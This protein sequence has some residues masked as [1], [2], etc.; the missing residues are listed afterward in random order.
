MNT[1]SFPFPRCW[2][3]PELTQINRLPARSFHFPFPNAEKAATRDPAKSKWVRSLD[4]EWNFDYF[5]R[6]EAVPGEWIGQVPG[7]TSRIQVPGNW[8]R[9]GW[10]KPH[11][12]NV[13]M[14]FENT[15]PQV[16]NDNPTGLYRK[17]ISIPKNWKGRRTLLQLG[18]V[19][20]V[21]GVY[22]DGNFVGWSTDSRLPAEFDL[23]PWL[24]PGKEHLLSVLVIR[25]SAFS[26]VED[27]DHWWMAGI[28][29]SV[30]LI[31]TDQVWFEDIFAKTAYKPKK[32]VGHLDLNIQ[33][34]LSG[35][36]GRKCVVHVQLE[37][38]HGKTLWKKPLKQSV[39]GT[40]YRTD[41]FVAEFYETVE[42]CL[43]WSAEQPHL[44]K[45][46]LELRDEERGKL[47]EATCIRI[48]FKSVKIKKGQ[49][50]FNGQPILIKGVNRHDHDPDHGK[51]MDRKW[52]IEDALLLKSHNFN[53]VRTAHYPNDPTWLEICDEVG[54]YVIDEANQE[55]HAN[56]ET[57]GHDPRWQNTCVERATRMVMR[58]RNH[59]S[60]YAWSLGNET[61]YGRNHDLEADA[62][63]VLDDSRLL[64]NEPADRS[65]WKQ[66]G[67]EFTPGGERSSDFRCPMYPEV[68]TFI[69]YGKNPTDTR[70]FI[71]CEYSHAMGNSNGCLKD[72]WDAI[73]KYPSLQGGYIWDWVEQGL[74]ESA[75]NGKE[76]WAY[77]GDFGDEPN[78]VNFNCNGLVQADRIPKPAMQECKKIFQPVH[79]S[80]FD[81]KTSELSL[82]NRE[83]FRNAKWIEWTYTLTCNGNEL[84]AAELGSISIPPQ[85][86]KT[87]HLKLPK[88]KPS[89][90]EEFVLHVCGFS[91]GFEI[92]RESF[93][94]SSR[95]PQKVSTDV[96]APKGPEFLGLT[97]FPELQ[98]IRGYTDNDGVKGKQEQWTADWK[99]LGRW[100][101]AGLDQVTL[102]K[103][104]C[105]TIDQTLHY[106]REYSTP[107]IPEA[108][109]HEQ[110]LT[111]FS[112]GWLC[113]DQRF[114]FDSALPDLPRVGIR[115]EL[116][117]AFEVI[118][119]MGLG[120]G[121]SYSD[122]K[123]GVWPGHFS[124][125]LE[126]QL[127]PYVVPQESGNREGL[128]WICARDHHGNG[129]MACSD[130]KF[131]GSILPYTSEQLIESLHPYELPTT[132]KAYLSL[133]V[134]QRGLGTASCGPD[135]LDRYKI[136]PGEY[137]FRWWLKALQPGDQP[138]KLYK[139]L[140]KN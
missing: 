91:E 99:P 31:S 34:G 9:Q 125:K 75:P 54:L 135:T 80:R 104:T 6:P 68:E 79:P 102:E 132:G 3:I 117:G 118:E 140:P 25:Y 55:A 27:Q 14:P 48:G 72:T 45:L 92:C 130:Q 122:R 28:Y 13:Q 23:T 73:Y 18:G 61:G 58:D 87:L 4:G 128:R 121:E 38:P 89:S 81:K 74:R 26:Y 11:Y 59:A 44:Y 71:P 123:A 105:E 136:Y 88:I 86:Q 77:G 70:P 41:G 20:S 37:D 129:V 82:V 69:S 96:V 17:T 114:H 95:S 109:R 65:S 1:S 107:H 19:E 39:D 46:H 112:N 63:R 49:M 36:P 57:L 127:F 43:A 106:L 2:E 67:S 94:V 134:A 51:T 100:H 120:P 124:G 29:R 108:I 47:I 62:I 7:E 97:H 53:A 50:L 33:L 76:Y 98:I 93:V 85:K 52:L 126:D 90:G 40:S 21:A 66:G 35:A 8:T 139:K 113:A 103:D 10:D 64:H 138:E 24:V 115:L 16:P 133:D 110:F 32:K 116:D 15:P 78:D 30:N 12:T 84:Y 131:S 119:W 5:E 137:R 56:Y 83:F 101:S 111:F 60:I 22:L 42:E